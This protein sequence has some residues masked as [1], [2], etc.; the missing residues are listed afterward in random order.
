MT[1]ES[2]YDASLRDFP[3]LAGEEGDSARIERAIEAAP[4]GVLYIPA[5]VYRIDR[6]IKVTNLCSLLMHKSAVLRAEE[7]ME[8]VL[9]Y[10]ASLQH[11]REIRKPGML[12]DYNLFIKGGCL[13]GNGH[14]SCLMLTEYHH[15]TLKDT[16]LLNGRTYGLRTD[17]YGHGYELIAT[18]VYAKCTMSGLGGNVAFSLKGGDSHYTDCVVVDYTIGFEDISWA[19]ANRFTRCHVWGGPLPARTEGGEREMLVDSICFKICAGGA[20]LRDCY[21]DT[22]KI[23]FYI[24]AYT[25][26]LGCSYFNNYSAFK[27]DDLIAIQH[28]RGKL[29]VAECAFTKTNPRAV[30]YASKTSDPAVWSN[31]IYHGFADAELPEAERNTPLR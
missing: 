23:G 14:A 3:R 21:A 7:D 24:D 26:L 30:V 1:D 5:G 12:E 4:S 18:N 29:L 31:N 2:F 19:G 17:D 25:R 16:T 9:T 8:T 20:V 22:A 27:L 10:D 6:P 15:F 13:D 11:K 28:V